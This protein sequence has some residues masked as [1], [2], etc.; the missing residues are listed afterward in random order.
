MTT[1]QKARLADVHRR[2]ADTERAVSRRYA[3]LA[4]AVRLSFEHLRHGL[5]L[6]HA[7]C[8][9]VED[10]H[11]ADYV[12]QLD[13]GLAELDI[14][15]NRAASGGA[16]PSAPEVL[17]IHT[18]A[19]E[20]AGWRLRTSLPD[21]GL[22]EPSAVRSRLAAAEAELEQYRAECVTGRASATALERRVEEL[23]AGAHS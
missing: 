20:L 1:T 10:G 6:A 9:A 12:A 19:V 5:E 8:S 15:I 3:D 23:R 13:R 17:V 4:A 14:E 21:S 18:T 22:E 2:V 7:R 16:G 11:W